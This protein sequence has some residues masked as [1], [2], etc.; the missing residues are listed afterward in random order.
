MKGK[1]KKANSPMLK[2]Q[3][4][5][6]LHQY[7]EGVSASKVEKLVLLCACIYCSRTANLHKC[8]DEMGHLL[9]GKIQEDSCYKIL[10][11]F[12]STGCGESLLE[13]IFRFV[14]YLLWIENEAILLLDRTNWEYGK[15]KIINLLVVGVLYKGVFI[16]LVWQDLDRAGNS[17]CEQR[18]ALVDKLIGWWR[19]IDIELPTLYIIGDREFMGQYWLLGLQKR[20]IWYVMRLKGNRKFELWHRYNNKGKV[21]KVRLSVIHRWLRKY[22]QPYAEVVIGDEIIANLVIKPLN[23]QTNGHLYLITNIDDALK[24]S[25]LYKLRWGIESCFKHLK[26]NGFELESQNMTHTHKI[27]L[28]FGVLALTY[29]LAVREGILKYEESNKPIPMKKYKNGRS[30]MKKSIFRKGLSRIKTKV[31][32]LKSCVKYL[33]LILNVIQHTRKSNTLQYIQII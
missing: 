24:A 22:K 33:V 11:R 31:Y 12:F 28:L 3:E 20:G 23:N 17:S 2:L 18:L 25:E 29:V 15:R 7:F 1:K 32:S 9:K 4:I 26:T 19:K 30:A 16:P 14:I 10:T 21:R 8:A 5:T 27:E 13:G 6:D